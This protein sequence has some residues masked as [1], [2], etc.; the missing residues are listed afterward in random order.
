MFAKMTVQ[1]KNKIQM[2]RLVK[3]EERTL[4]R[5]TN[6]YNSNYS[7]DGLDHMT[8]EILRLKSKTALSSK[9]RYFYF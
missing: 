7:M 1:Q 9:N 8:K 6:Q 2:Q 5:K 3:R 4:Q